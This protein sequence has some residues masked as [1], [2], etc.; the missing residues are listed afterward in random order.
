LS[1]NKRRQGEQVR[2]LHGANPAQHVST[3][4]GQFWKPG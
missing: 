1:V 4:P 2:T 3:H